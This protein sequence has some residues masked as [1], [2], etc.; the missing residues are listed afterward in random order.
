M[1]IEIMIYVA[2]L[3]TSITNSKCGTLFLLAF[4]IDAYKYDSIDSSSTLLY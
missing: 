3:F 2:L 1:S 4:L